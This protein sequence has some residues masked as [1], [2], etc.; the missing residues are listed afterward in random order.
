MANPLM[1]P[2]K[3]IQVQWL[4]VCPLR[5][6]R[7]DIS[8]PISFINFFGTKVSRMAA[9]IAFIADEEPLAKEKQ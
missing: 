1:A 3:L 4:D 7:E 9:E 8:L 5:A 2:I 6:P